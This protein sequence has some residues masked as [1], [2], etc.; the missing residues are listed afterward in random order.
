VL[1]ASPDLGTIGPRVDYGP[2]IDVQ[3][4]DPIPLVTMP[5]E[6]GWA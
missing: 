5:P 4:G 1:S 6:G 3:P 2:A